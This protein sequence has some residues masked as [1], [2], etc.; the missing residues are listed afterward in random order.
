MLRNG[1]KRDSKTTSLNVAYDGRSKRKKTPKKGPLPAVE[2]KSTGKDRAEE[3]L[4]Q[5]VFGADEDLIDNLLQKDDSAV[6]SDEDRHGRHGVVG[7]AVSRKPAWED[8][9]DVIQSVKLSGDKTREELQ[10]GN[11]EVLS[12][13]QYLS[14]IQ[15]KFE[16]VSGNPNWARLDQVKE[17][18]EDSEDELLH[19]T[20]SYVTMSDSLPNG[21][22]Q[23][24]KCR[25]VN[26]E[27]RTASGKLRSVEFH[28]SAQV[29]LTAGVDQ[30]ARLFQVDGKYN[31]KIESIYFE[32][33]PIH[34][35][36]FSRNGEEIIVSSK[37]GHFYYYNMIAGKIIKVPWNKATEQAELKRFELSPD[38]STIVFYG[39]YGRMHILSAKTK[40]LISTLKMN[41]SVDAISFSSDGR[42]M[43]SHG[44][45]GQVYMWDMGSRS[46]THKFYDE[47][48]IKGTSVACSPN[49][50]YIACGSSSGVVN[51]YDAVTC[52]TSHSPA[53]LKVV[54]NMTT[55]VTDLRFN[56]TSEI[57]AMLSR[58]KEQAVKLVHFPSMSVFSN[59]P[60]VR[61]KD[62]RIPLCQD[63]SLNSGYYTIGDHKGH[64]FLYRL[65]HY[66][67]Y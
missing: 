46:C 4:E 21:V 41:G 35:A 33:F 63:F 45:D 29:V 20:G 9:D 16:K 42:Q 62:M 28:P 8:E 66:S 1:I 50:Q 11:E 34:T 18:D 26:Y 51:V 60:G 15:S 6:E 59:F 61:E 17:N 52:V 31:P 30:R 38:G 44:D 3:I 25:N 7:D 19:H 67:N 39:N 64:A 23:M 24:A 36:H 58:E 57:L 40:E 65:K 32:K 5:L 12:G 56:C 47:G 13:D 55:P 43:F 10:R 48:C 2:A 54:L 27:D 14:R 53:P 49:G 37:F 22:I